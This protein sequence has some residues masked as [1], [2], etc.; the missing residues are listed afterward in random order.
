MAMRE[1]LATPSCLFSF[2]STV[3][4]SSSAPIAVPVGLAAQPAFPLSLARAV[5]CI[6]AH[7][8]FSAK[9]PRASR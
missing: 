3:S 6:S 2:P 8:A 7:S 4:S 1:P 5:T 9:T